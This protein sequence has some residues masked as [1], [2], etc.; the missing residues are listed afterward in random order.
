MGRVASR[1]YRHAPC[2]LYGNG[3][4]GGYRPLRKAIARYLGLARRVDCSPEQIVVTTGS[5][6]ALYL[7]TRLLLDPGDTVWVEDRGYSG[8]YSVFQAVG[9][10][11]VSTPGHA[12][13]IDV[14]AGTKLAPQAKLAYVTPANQFP[15]GMTM[16][17]AR[18]MDLL[19]WASH[20]GAWII[21]HDYD[22]EYRYSKRPL[23]GCRAWILSAP[24]ST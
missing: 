18:R 3:S 16:S 22:S 9:A 12:G 4:A 13:R 17:A 19:R 5:Q 2:W 23:P 8:S 7:V 24:S 11:I 6:R 20:A 21:D 10:S 14:K 1:V 15:L